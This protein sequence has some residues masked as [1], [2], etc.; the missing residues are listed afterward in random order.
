[1]AYKPKTVQELI[2]GTSDDFISQTFQ[3]LKVYN[4]WM[5]G[6][7][8]RKYKQMQ[9]KVTADSYVAENIQEDGNIMKD[10]PNSKDAAD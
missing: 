6:V 10:N 3:A 8:D 7:E 2:G 5:Q 9:R 4:Q 1:M